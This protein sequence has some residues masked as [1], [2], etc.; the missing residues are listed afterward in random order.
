M[1]YKIAVTGGKGGTGKSTIAVILSK[2][3]SAEKN[4][5]VLLVD[6]DVESPSDHIL[7]G[8]ERKTL[9]S[10]TMF[11]PEIIQEKC[12]KCGECIK[13]CPEHALIGLE[14]TYPKLIE[15]LC[16]GCKVCFFVCQDNA[17]KP[18]EEEIGKIY[19]GEKS[20][21]TMLQGELNPGK[22]QYV[23]M[24]TRVVD[25]SKELAREFPLIIYDTAPGTGANV[26]S[27]LRTADIV[28]AVTEP[29]PLG[30]NDL[31]MLMELV[32][33]LGKKAF[34]VLNRSDLPGGKSELI[35]KVAEKW[36]IEIIS[37]VP[38]S[39]EF[40]EKYANGE[41]IVDFYQH[42][43]FKELRNILEVL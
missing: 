16:S 41:P 22:R 20:K 37:R 10:V 21:I 26:F 19:M 35:E 13:A 40:I 29:T 3:L 32:S 36:N 24:T 17:I 42:E 5:K 11:K 31:N 39:R 28:I 1:A 30:A 2:L 43:T 4:S 18:S 27:V 38:F 7:L 9:E 14:G 33:D 34:I 25:K 23:T 15:D 6:T 12:T 8:V